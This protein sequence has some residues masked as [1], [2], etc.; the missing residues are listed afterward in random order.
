M[1]SAVLV[2]CKSGK[3]DASPP[4]AS[5]TPAVTAATCE[6]AAAGLLRLCPS[7]AVD[8]KK[9]PAGYDCD[10]AQRLVAQ[11][12]V[13]L[14]NVGEKVQLRSQLVGTTWAN[15]ES[16]TKVTFDAAKKAC[17]SCFDR[18]PPSAAAGEACAACFLRP[19]DGPFTVSYPDGKRRVVGANAA[20]KLEGTVSTFHEN[21]I[22]SEEK[23][24]R[25]GVLHGPFTA[26][27]D[28]NRKIRAGAYDEGMLHGAHSRFDGTRVVEQGD[29]QYGVRTG[30]WMKWYPSGKKRSQRAYRTQCEGRVC[31][32]KRH[33][34]FISW[35]EAG[36]VSSMTRYAEGKRVALDMDALKKTP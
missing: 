26:W 6:T 29:Y 16:R 23:T 18:A 17:P 12:D 21:G 28:G 3:E 15:L 14:R 27:D 31:T 20:G 33:G 19:F 1:L 22:K 34:V 9:T 4:P 36:K 30:R 25:A 24:Y 13:L 5:E 35:D 2:G 10:G 32:A 7:C 11:L 8:P